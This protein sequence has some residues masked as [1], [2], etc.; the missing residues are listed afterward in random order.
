MSNFRP[1]YRYALVPGGTTLQDA[2]AFR[3]AQHHEVYQVANLPP[4]QYDRVGPRLWAGRNPLTAIDIER[5]HSD[6]ITHLLDLREP[7]EW[8]PPRHGQAALDEVERA[9]LTRLHLP[10]TDMGAPL[11]ADLQ[12]AIGFI[13]E[14]LSE[15]RTGLYVHC[16]AGMER[17]AAILVAW[18]AQRY[19]SSYESS[20]AALREGRPILRPLPVQEAAVRQRLARPAYA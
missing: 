15:P 16:R 19:R 9:G 17:T 18:W 12:V 4:F 7:H 11:S 6:G 5:L 2:K 10:I 14:I 1:S 3:L 13:D 20:L 8:V